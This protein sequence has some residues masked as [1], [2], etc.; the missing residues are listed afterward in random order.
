MNDTSAARLGP[1]D[2]SWTE[3]RRDH[4]F[5]GLIGPLWF[6][7][8]GDDIVF[9]VRA[10]A[11]HCNVRGVVHG[12]LMMTLLDHVMGAHVWRVAGKAASATV[13]LNTDFTASARTGDWI[14]VR[15]RMT[16]RGTGLVFLAGE[17]SVE[18]KPIATAQGV[19]KILGQR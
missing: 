10:E 2:E 8:E 17:L 4:G 14:E 19:W 7:R 13:S 6:R 15:S 18:G 9:G 1:P 12:G 16:R 11:K 3:F 5:T